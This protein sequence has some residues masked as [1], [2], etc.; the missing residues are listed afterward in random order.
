MQI[1]GQKSRLIF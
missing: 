1:D